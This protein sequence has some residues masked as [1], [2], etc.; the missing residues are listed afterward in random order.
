[1]NQLLNLSGNLVSTYPE[2]SA[3][4]HSVRTGSH[5]FG[6]FLQQN[7]VSQVNKQ[8]IHESPSSSA[9]PINESLN[10]SERTTLDFFKSGCDSLYSV[11]PVGWTS[12]ES[13]F[14]ALY[15]QEI[16]LF[17]EVSSLLSD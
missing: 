4:C 15:G 2:M 5:V 14:D 11:Y 1:M 10:I 12:E 16:C 17:S 13:W 8:L 6:P 3:S 7:F 9:I